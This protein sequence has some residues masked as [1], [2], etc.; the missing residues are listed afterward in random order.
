MISVF[1]KAILAKQAEETQPSDRG[2]ELLDW[3]ECRWSAADT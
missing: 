2:L 3:I 1:V